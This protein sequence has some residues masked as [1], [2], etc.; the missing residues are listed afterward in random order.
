MNDWRQGQTWKMS[1]SPLKT[2]IEA[3][4]L[5]MMAAMT[6][7]L[8]ET[9]AGILKWVIGTIGLQNIVTLGAAAAFVKLV[10]H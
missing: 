5:S 4:R 9:K 3:L 1:G 7:S 8:A 2:D 6:T 10:T